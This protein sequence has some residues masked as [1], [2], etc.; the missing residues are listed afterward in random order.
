MKLFPLGRIAFGIHLLCN[1]VSFC[2]CVPFSGLIVLFF[3]FHNE[4]DIEV[5][6]GITK[7]FLK[8]KLHFFFCFDG[9]TFY[10]VIWLSCIVCIHAEN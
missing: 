8:P 1:G 3:F 5:L 9:W 2:I 6:A 10:F 4:E 7:Q